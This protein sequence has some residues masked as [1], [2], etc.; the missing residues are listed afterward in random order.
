MSL[1]FSSTTT[2]NGI[3]Q[4]CERNCGFNDG[5]IS[6]NNTRLAQFTGMVNM[7]YDDA[8]AIIFKVGGLWQFDDSNHTGYPFITT[9]MVSGQRDYTFTNEEDGN[10]ILDLYKVM[11]KDQNGVYFELQPVDQQNDADMESF[12]SGQNV[13]GTPYRY[14]KTGN[15]IFLDVIPSYNATAGVKLFINREA[16][17]FLTSDA[18]KKPGIDGLCH[19]YLPLKASYMYAR[20]KGLPQ[21]V[22]LEKDV[23][24]AEQKIKE[25]YGRRERDIERVMAPT[26]VCSV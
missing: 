23:L 6:G 9:N 19:E 10:L 14:D 25:R 1:V 3:I 18:A 2:K 8:L 5:D 17:Y 26:P 24:L 16:S 7:A 22:R 11:V 13:T 21:V 15:G 12:Y 20:D 4:V